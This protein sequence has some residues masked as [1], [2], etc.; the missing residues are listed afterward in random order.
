LTTCADG[1]TAATKLASE[2]CKAAAAANPE[3]INTILIP[4]LDQDNQPGSWWIMKDASGSSGVGMTVEYHFDQEY[5]DKLVEQKFYDVKTNEQDSDVKLAYEESEWAVMHE[6]FML[7]AFNDALSPVE[8]DWGMTR[9]WEFELTIRFY[10]E[11]VPAR[12]EPFKV[13]AREVF[14]FPPHF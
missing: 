4:Q 10:L 14:F 1:E 7:E 6:I 5:Y 8:F 3:F 11:L 13:I 2:A 9:W 12:S